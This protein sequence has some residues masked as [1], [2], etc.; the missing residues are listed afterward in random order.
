MHKIYVINEIVK[1]LCQNLHFV[2]MSKWRPKYEFKTVALLGSSSTFREKKN[3]TFVLD[4][5]EQSLSS[6]YPLLL[7]ITEIE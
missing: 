7:L 1:K 4:K 3:S 6:N 2:S 5:Y